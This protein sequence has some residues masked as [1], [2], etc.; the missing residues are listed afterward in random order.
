MPPLVTPEWDA[1]ESQPE[2]PVGSTNQKQRQTVDHGDQ[3]PVRWP[4]GVWKKETGYVGDRVDHDASVHTQPVDL[5]ADS[6]IRLL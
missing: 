3:E 6:H 2:S 1:K 4:P 5:V